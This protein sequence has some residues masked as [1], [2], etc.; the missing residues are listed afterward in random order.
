[1]EWVEPSGGVV[2]L[3]PHQA[4]R[5][6]DVDAFYRVL[7]EDFGTYV[8]P[9]HWF[10]QSRRHFRLGFGW[11]TLGR[12][13]GRPRRDLGG[14]ASEPCAARLDGIPEHARLSAGGRD[15]VRCL[16]LCEKVKKIA[17][18]TPCKAEDAG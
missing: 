9:G 18:L 14:A 8:G 12:A 1:M 7:T 13:E 2:V 5:P 11:P 17:P 4:G 16:R 3:P 6:V 10:E 15:F